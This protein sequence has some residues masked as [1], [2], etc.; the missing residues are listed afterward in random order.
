M[1]CQKVRNGPAPNVRAA[2]SWSL[3]TS[4]KTGST[5]RNTYGSETAMVAITM[6]TGENRIVIPFLLNH[7]PNQPIRE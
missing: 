1:I 7:A 2:C 3:P 6:P 5:D 4:I